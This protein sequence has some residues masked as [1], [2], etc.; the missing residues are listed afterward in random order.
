MKDHCDA[1]IRASTHKRDPA[2]C[3]PDTA[4]K[5]GCC[6]YP[7]CDQ[8]KCSSFTFE[9]NIVYEYI[10]IGSLLRVPYVKS[11]C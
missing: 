1:S 11:C 10:Y 7:G 4:P 6:C 3:H 5:V 8:G 2:T 9:R